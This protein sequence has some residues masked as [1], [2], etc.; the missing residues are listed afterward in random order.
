MQKK[1]ILTDLE[2]EDGE[3]PDAGVDTEGAEGGEGGGGSDAEC[4]EVCDGG[5]GDGHPGMGHSGSH[6]LRD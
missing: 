3:D 6:P 5:D 1:E 2:R 4:N